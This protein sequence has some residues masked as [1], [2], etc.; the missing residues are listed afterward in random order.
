[1]NRSFTTLLRRGTAVVLAAV[2]GVA[3]AGSDASTTTVTAPDVPP[4]EMCPTGQY[5]ILAAYALDDGRL[6]WVTCDTS[7]DV[8]IAVA[9]DAD[10]VWVQVPYPLQTLRIDAR[11][12]ALLDTSTAPNP[13]FPAGADIALRTPPASATIQVGGGQDDPL[14]GTEIATGTIR[15]TADGHPVYDDIWAGD[16]S[17]VYASASDPTGAQPGMWLVAYAIDSGEARWRVPVT[18]YSWPWHAAGGLVFAMWYD[19]HVFDAV[20]GTERWHTD[21]GEPSG[22]FPRMFGAVTNDEMV[23]VSF[24]S[25]GAGGD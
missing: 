18:D 1:M 25:V 12:G 8:H 22:G 5:P 13:T 9:A 6:Q 2:A 16:S 20:D 3:C 21:Y 15:W 17:T 10:H 11:T 7:R 4:S 24:T 23:F 14:T 19:L